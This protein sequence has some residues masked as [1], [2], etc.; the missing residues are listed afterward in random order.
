MSE[1]LTIRERLF[2]SVTT[3]EVAP[4]LEEVA[5]ELGVSPVELA[6]ILNHKDV[7]QI[8]QAKT[9]ARAMLAMD[10]C[11]NRLVSMANSENDKTAQAA[12]SLITKL[13]GTMKPQAVNI[14]LNF[15]ELIK[16]AAQ[17]SAG[18]LSNITQIREAEVIDADDDDDDTTE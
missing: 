10:A 13:S 2:Q 18:P 5:A 16:Q 12:I 6:E 14:R 7:T 8:I 11:M 17:A 9:K 3:V 4:T 15:D 1:A